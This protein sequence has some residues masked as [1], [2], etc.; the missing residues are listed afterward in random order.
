MSWTSSEL[1]TQV[2]WKRASGDVEACL[3][4]V[5]QKWYEAWEEIVAA[6]KSPAL[7]EIRLAEDLEQTKS[8]LPKPSKNL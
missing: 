3:R 7:G 8:I 1:T 4:K 5:L 2:T 6:L